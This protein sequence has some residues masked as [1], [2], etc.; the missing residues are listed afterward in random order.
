MRVVCAWV[1]GLLGVAC[2]FGSEGAGVGSAATIGSR[3]DDSPEPATESTGATTDTGAEGTGSN[4]SSGD[5]ATPTG[6]ADTGGPASTSEDGADD[7]DP[8]LLDLPPIDP[9]DPDPYGE[10]GS[11]PVPDS[12][13]IFDACARPCATSAACPPGLSGT[14]TPTCNAPYWDHCDLDCAMGQKCPEGMQCFEHQFGWSCG[15]P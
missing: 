9:P 8:P 13:C 7:F 6:D 11:C 14:A 15:W 12:A 4:T 2:T 5:T 1:L 3:G 10:C